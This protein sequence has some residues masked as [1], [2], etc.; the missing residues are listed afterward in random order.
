[1]ARRPEVVHS[2]PM[3]LNSA[4]LGKICR[5][6]DSNG[7]SDIDILTLTLTLTPTESVS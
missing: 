4:F 5:L 7:D 3:Q 2:F 1:M 6:H